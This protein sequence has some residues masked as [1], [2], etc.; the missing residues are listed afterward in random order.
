VREHTLPRVDGLIGAIR[1]HAVEWVDV[2]KLG[3][4]YLQ[5]AVPLTV[6]PEWSGWTAQLA[7]ARDRLER[8]LAELHELAIGGTAVGTGLNAPTGDGGEIAARLAGE[9]AI[10]ASAGAHGNLEL[11]TMRPLV[12]TNV[13]HSARILGDACESLHRNSVEGTELDRQA[14]AEHVHRSLML[15]TALSPHLGYAKTAAIA[16][17][18]HHDD[19]TLRAAALELGVRA[20]DFD[21]I[22]DPTRMVGNPR[23]DLGL[24]RQDA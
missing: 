16:H 8:S 4:T 21:R 2:V 11:N 22:V 17:K 10:V 19:S 23:Q 18:A 1:K 6:G 15:V 9:D 5:D 24:A 3:R 13:L 20:A 7:G 12:I 14:I